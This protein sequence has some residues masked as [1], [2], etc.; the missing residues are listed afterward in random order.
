MSEREPVLLKRG[1]LA[2]TERIEHR[3]RPAVRKTVRM[4]P[5][6]PLV[7]REIDRWLAGREV[8]QLTR[9]EGVPGVPRVLARPAEHVYVRE[10][11]EGTPLPFAPAP[12]PVCSVALAPSVTG[13]P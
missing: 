2:A 9:A 10:F 12:P 7:S 13:S 8:R 3:G 4:R 5:R 11:V 6:I 1:R